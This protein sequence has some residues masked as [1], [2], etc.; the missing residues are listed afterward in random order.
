MPSS[1]TT[2]QSSSGA[3][4]SHGGSS[5]SPSTTMSCSPPHPPA[6]KESLQSSN[7]TSPSPS[8]SA[9][10][11]VSR[12][13]SRSLSRPSDCPSH[14][15]TSNP[16]ATATSTNN[17]NATSPSAPYPPVVRPY[18]PIVWAV[19]ANGQHPVFVT[20]LNPPLELGA[21][22]PVAKSS[23][24]NLLSKSSAYDSPARTSMCIIR[25]G[26]P[27]TA[28]WTTRRSGSFVALTSSRPLSP[29]HCRTPAMCFTAW[30][31]TASTILRLAPFKFDSR[32]WPIPG[33]STTVITVWA[34]PSVTTRWT[35]HASKCPILVSSV[36]RTWRHTTST[37]SLPRAKLVCT[38]PGNRC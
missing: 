7:A 3:G 36:S 20:A 24:S 21:A 18:G 15:P 9:L 4:P 27:G 19:Y 11:A 1:I 30:L 28:T 13:M 32:E 16:N 31:A 12:S 8:N 29:R 38:S 2:S 22:R 6:G 23:N 5:P 10:C 34:L 26:N 17:T 37:T 25:S 14:K 33:S 35:L